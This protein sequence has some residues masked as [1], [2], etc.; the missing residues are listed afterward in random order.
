[1]SDD[2]KKLSIHPRNWPDRVF[3]VLGWK[4]RR[5][6]NTALPRSAVHRNRAALGIAE[7]LARHPNDKASEA[8]YS[9]LTAT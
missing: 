6:K 9:A 3:S 5:K 8:R 1:M 2:L 4:E 7:H